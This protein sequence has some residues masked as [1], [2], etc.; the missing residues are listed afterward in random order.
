MDDGI[1]TLKK[2]E[3]QVPQTMSKNLCNQTEKGE[4]EVL[5]TITN[6]NKIFAL[7]KDEDLKNRNT[8]TK[9]LDTYMADQK[10][11]SSIDL[12]FKNLLICED[13]EI[14]KMN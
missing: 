6:P 4:G 10:G 8:L 13:D 1:P 12:Q 11:L 2:R 3:F 5:S 9:G 7:S 14:F